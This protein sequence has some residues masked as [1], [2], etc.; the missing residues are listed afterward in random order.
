MSVTARGL[1]KK[2]EELETASQICR[3]AVD[4]CSR[5][6]ARKITLIWECEFPSLDA[7]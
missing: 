4:A 1:E 5:F 2:F 6:R 3:R 7:A